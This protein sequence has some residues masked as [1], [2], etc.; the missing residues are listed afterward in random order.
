MRNLLLMIAMSL[1][2]LVGCSPDGDA[3]VGPRDDAPQ[4]AATIDAD[5]GTVTAVSEGVSSSLNFPP[6][7]L[8]ETTRIALLPGEAEEGELARFRID[9]DERRLRR[10]ASFRFTLPDT[11][12][13]ERL[14]IFL[15]TGARRVP[16]VTS[17]DGGDLVA[18]IWS[19]GLDLGDIG[20]GRSGGLFSD[21]F[22]AYLDCQWE[23]DLV[24]EEL[25]RL[26]AWMS[27]DGEPG[28]VTSRTEQLIARLN[29]VK[30]SCGGVEGTDELVQYAMTASC[31]RYREAYV[32]AAALP[33]PSDYD[34]MLRQIV[35][36]LSSHAVVENVG[37][38]ACGSP[39][40][41]L[42]QDELSSF[43]DQYAAEITAPGY[44][45][46]AGPWR[47]VW[48]DLRSTIGNLAADVEMLGV[49]EEVPVYEDLVYPLANILRRAAYQSCR[50]FNT[51][52]YLVDLLTGGW[53]LEHPISPT[54]D[55]SI[56]NLESSAVREDVEHCACE[57]TVKAFDAIGEVLA[58]E[59]LGGGD[60]P[61][62]AV[63]TAAMFVPAD[64]VLE[65]SGSVRAFRC[66]PPDR[67]AS[68][69]IDRLVVRIGDDELAS[70]F[71]GADGQYLS[72]PLDVSME[73]V[74]AADASR[75]ILLTVHRVGPACGG[76]YAGHA[77]EAEV[78]TQLLEIELRSNFVVRDGEFE[79]G[80]WSHDLFVN[81]PSGAGRASVAR[82][83]SAGNPGAA[84][85]GRH[86][87]GPGVLTYGHL[88]NEAWY[89]PAT[90]GPIS[91]VSFSIQ[92]SV[93]AGGGACGGDPGNPQV[94][95]GMLLH[96]D[97]HYFKTGEAWL[98][99]GQVSGWVTIAARDLTAE[100]FRRIRADGTTE[101]VHPDFTEKG[102]PITLGYGTGNSTGL[103]T[104]V[105]DWKV[106]NFYVEVVPE[107]R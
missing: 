54:S 101:A 98:S 18:E 13:P 102:N 6:G 99:A 84:Q 50:E 55:P 43:V 26:N 38:E 8:G 41:P 64:G 71:A 79:D 42:I 66:E 11:V 97:G 20:T 58:E 10:P 16:L 100:D 85:T 83:G 86:D 15:E 103:D 5:G 40:Y 36:V 78:D 49:A 22:I 81:H 96:Q 88:N 82:S 59:S 68:W 107:E 87:F 65:F 73:D 47:L 105:R 104:C 44:L 45:D 7:S 12:A 33:P 14:A 53:Y 62:S 35:P 28:I 31:D 52:V 2:T 91:S 93:T 32:D 63:T 17:V 90:D 19:F 75:P 29:A 94:S 9:A 34:T 69:S 72:T 1:E 57:F 92:F 77:G 39:M 51:Q 74:L 60:A 37:V 106:D 89:A 27:M 4:E 67:S 24:R 70:R 76:W 23:H 21:A 46:G 30:I 3:G 61:G 95:C 80:D 25:V 56:L 48:A